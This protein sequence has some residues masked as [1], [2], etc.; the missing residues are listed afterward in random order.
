MMLPMKNQETTMRRILHLNVIGG[1][2]GDMV[3]GGLLDLGVPFSLLE[4]GMSQLESLPLRLSRQKTKRHEISGTHFH[5]ESLTG[6]AHPH[7]SFQTIRQLIGNSSLS[8]QVKELALKIFKQL[9]LV[10]GKIHNKL[11]EDVHFHE[12]GAWD[13][14]ADIVCVA[15]CLDYL[16]I[17]G[18]Y[19]SSIPL[20][21]GFVKTA[22][23]MM[24]IPAPATLELLHGFDIIQDTLPFERTT[25][26]GAAILAALAEPQSDALRYRV[27]RIGIGTGSQDRSEVPNIIRCILGFQK[28]SRVSEDNLVFELVE[29]S[30]TNIDDC[31]PECLGFVHEQ[32]MAAG[33]L[34]AWFIPIQMKKNRPGVLLQILH[35]PEK[36][37]QLHRLVF[38]ETTSLG[39]RYRN[40]HRTFLKRAIVEVQTPWGKVRG[41]QSVFEEQ[42]R[43]SPEFE[44]C[45]KIAV[46]HG[47]SLNHI[48]S[49][50]EESYWKQQKTH[51]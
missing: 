42:S 27:D 12:V 39:I 22:H 2:A 45:R 32:L 33:A 19:V 24:P 35:A 50:V 51:R 29:C 18:I 37:W 40:F 28:E 30:E 26:T 1:I 43:F 16:E 48:F 46:A 49:V 41:K 14:I 8:F 9:A 5:V 47:I 20:G 23:G 34:D 25:P 13:S 15:L 21:T 6:D 17:A 38:Q 10:E 44:D 7:R 3:V 11:P 36:R 31:T 4:E